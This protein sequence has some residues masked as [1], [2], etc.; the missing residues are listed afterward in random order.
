MMPTSAIALQP[1]RSDPQNPGAVRPWVLWRPKEGAGTAGRP[2]PNEFANFS[3]V[4][5]Y[6]SEYTMAA[7]DVDDAAQALIFVAAVVVMA[8]LLLS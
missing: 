3:N 4:L 1:S 7:S 2:R 6:T 5:N 8:A